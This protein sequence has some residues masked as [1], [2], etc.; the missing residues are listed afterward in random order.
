MTAWIVFGVSGLITFVMRGSFLLFGEKVTMPNWTDAP[1]RYVAP[2]AFAAIAL[3]AALGTDG[4]ASLWP[5]TAEVV[6]VVAAVVIIARTRNIPLCLVGGL[7]VLWVGGA[8][9]L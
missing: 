6:G 4:V 5:P 7:I 1:L 8:L 9:G 3:P 2:A